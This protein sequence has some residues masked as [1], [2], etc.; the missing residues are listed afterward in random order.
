MTS[1]KSLLVPFYSHGLLS[2]TLAQDAGN[3][4]LS[5]AAASGEV[6]STKP[7]KGGLSMPGS[8]FKTLKSMSFKRRQSQGVRANFTGLAATQAFRDHSSSIKH[9]GTFHCFNSRL[10]ST[11]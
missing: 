8:A 10:S 9:I 2:S 4:Q 5:T 3:A 11:F 6:A 1:L 7:Q